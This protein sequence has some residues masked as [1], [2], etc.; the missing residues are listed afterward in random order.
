MSKETKKVLAQIAKLCKGNLE[1][2]GEN[3]NPT[4]LRYET[5]IRGA[6]AEARGV[7]AA[8]K[9]VLVE[10]KLIRRNLKPRGE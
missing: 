6:K 1:A 3:Y 9:E 10:I 7:C 2:F 5:L 8:S 4:H